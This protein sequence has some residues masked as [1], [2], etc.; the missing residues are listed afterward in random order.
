[1][2]QLFILFSILIFFNLVCA[3][4]IQNFSPDPIELVYGTASF[5]FTLVEDQG[6]NITNITT[7]CGLSFSGTCNIN[8][9]SELNANTNV[10]CTG[11]ITVPQYTYAGNYLGKIEVT[12]LASTGNVY[13]DYNFNINILETHDLIINYDLSDMTSNDLQIVQVE[14]KNTGNIDLTVTSNVT[15]EDENGNQVSDIKAE[16]NETVFII[17]PGKSKLIELKIETLNANSGKYYAKLN[18][19]AENPS[20]LVSFTKTQKEPFNVL[21]DYC[22][23]NSTADYLELDIRNVDDFEGDNFEPYE[24]F[25]IEVRVTNNDNDEHDIVVEAVLVK[26]NEII[27]DSEVTEEITIDEDS[28]ETVTLTMEVPVIDE[29]RYDVYVRAYDDADELVCIQ[30]SSYIDVERPTRKVK[31]KKVFLDKE[32]Y[33]CGSYML[34]SGSIVNIGI[35]DEDLVK[36]VYSDD[37]GNEIETTFSLDEGNEKN[38]LFQPKVSENAS[39]GQHVFYLKIYYDYDDNTNS[40]DRIDNYAYYFN[41]QGN[42]IKPEKDVSLSIDIEDIMYLNNS[43]DGKIVLTNTGDLTTTYEIDVNAEWA[44]IELASSLVTLNPNEQKEIGIKINP[45]ETGDKTLSIVVKFDNEERTFTKTIRVR[46][47]EES[48]KYRK[49]TWFDEIRFE[50]ERRPWAFVIVIISILIAL[51]SLIGIIVLLAKK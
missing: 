2:K 38:F 15:I 12:G 49:A 24:T 30:D 47:Y 22:P 20:W 21:F 4:S 50:F 19:L 31:P 26:D 36:L 1:M 5:S 14:L 51:A 34:I 16:I 27:D 45:K 37:L 18:A 28:K 10:S 40:F 17:N 29:G 35:H 44:N 48:G 9:P 39:E 23:V 33:S 3:L 7:N 13:A 42:C 25:D 8:C 46:T 11:I 41:I 32:S 6:E 43:Y